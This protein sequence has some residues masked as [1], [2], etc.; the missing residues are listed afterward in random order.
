MSVGQR[1]LLVGVLLNNAAR[2]DE[3]IGVES[4]D[5]KFGQYL[6]ESQKLYRPYLVVTPQ[7]PSMPFRNY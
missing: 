1:K 7:K 6:N 3:S 2:P 5:R 4:L